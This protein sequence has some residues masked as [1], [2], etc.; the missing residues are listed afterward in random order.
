M[1]DREVAEA[2]AA[3]GARQAFGDKL[4][5]EGDCLV[6]DGWWEAAFRV[7]PTTFA[8]RDEEPPE[9]TDTLDQLRSRL[10]AAGLRPVD[11]NPALL[12]AITY[13]AI[14][15]GAA[16]WALW[17]SDTA[18]A[19]AALA[20]RAGH[21]TFLS[22][23]PLAGGPSAGGPFAGTSG[24][25]AES[26]PFGAEPGSDY[27]A[28]L[29]GA[30]RSAGLPALL[31][32]TVGLDDHTASA[33]AESLDDCRVEARALGDLDRHGCETLMPNLVLVDATTLDG[34]AF[35]FDLRSSGRSVPLVAVHADGPLV[36]ADA[37]VDPAAPPEQWATHLRALLP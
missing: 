13:T 27:A 21:D 33:V 37:T 20:A 32:L 19:D 17:S 14:D 11:A 30:R 34:Q 36:G 12:V 8:V 3:G 4:H 22:D 16:D 9:P 18:S 6:F 7:S 1:D 35:V 2:F 28:E 23:A 24:P 10:G 5:I 31:I 15:L 29:G 26:G 25:F